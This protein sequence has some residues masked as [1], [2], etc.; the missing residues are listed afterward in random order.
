MALLR[1]GGCLVLAVRG[2]SWEMSLT[3][4][5]NDIIVEAP[6]VLTLILQTGD[7]QIDEVVTATHLRAL[8]IGPRR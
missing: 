4:A 3:A 2:F 7:G 1:P 8:G 5:E 6:E